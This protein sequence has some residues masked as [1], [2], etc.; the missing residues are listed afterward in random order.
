MTPSV[1]QSF[2][3]SGQLVTNTSPIT[4]SNWGNR[5]A[6]FFAGNLNGPYQMFKW[7]ESAGKLLVLSVGSNRVVNEVITAAGNGMKAIGLP[8]TILMAKNLSTEVQEMKADPTSQRKRFLCATTFADFAT[9]TSYA[10]VAPFYAVAAKA[11]KVFCLVKDS[12]ESVRLF[13]DM[14]VLNR[15]RSSFAEGE[16]AQAF[17]V[18]ETATALKLVKAV[19]SVAAGI[20]GI[21]VL[22][23]LIVVSPTVTVALLAIALATATLSI[24]VHFYEKSA[25]ASA[26]QI[27][28]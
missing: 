27:Q 19:M 28:Y 4:S 23:D 2:T 21:A 1:T 26:L 6:E 13:L 8:Y 11:G 22:A 25:A 12:F 9:A 24:T 10:I 16:G 17:K 3:T 18:T 15:F 14:R 20:L 5:T 7:L